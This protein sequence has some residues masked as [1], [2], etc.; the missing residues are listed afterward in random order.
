MTEPTTSLVRSRSRQRG[1]TLIEL[2]AVMTIISILA[3]SLMVGIP[4]FVDKAE[5]SACRSNLSRVYQHFVALSDRDRDKGPP[6]EGGV[7][8]LAFLW[9]KTVDDPTLDEAKRFTCAAVPPGTFEGWTD[10]SGEFLPPEEIWGTAGV[11]KD[12]NVAL[13]GRIRQNG[14]GWSSYRVLDN[15][16][17][18]IKKWSSF[19]KASRPIVADG[20]PQVDDYAGDGDADDVELNHAKVTNV[21]MGD[22]NVETLY[23]D[24]IAELVDLT[25]VERLQVVGERAEH[26]DGKYKNLVFN[27][28]RLRD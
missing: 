17:G 16:D 11:T 10:E 6:R 28:G 23:W 18:D 1:F 19:L 13:R 21:L 24:D 4:F 12:S 7:A 14:K 8:M 22:G 15:S 27:P 9:Q 26:T 2:L 20:N 25:G 5:A 3:A